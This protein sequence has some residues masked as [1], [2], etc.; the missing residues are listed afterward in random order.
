MRNLRVSWIIP[1][2]LAV[3]V[4]A[5]AALK[6]YV[7]RGADMSQ[8]QLL[9]RIEE[10]SD[11]CIL[12]VRSARE[13]GSGHIPGAINVGYKEV[14]AHLDELGPYR[15]KDII[16]YCELGVRARMAQKTLSKAGFLHV[17]HLTGDMARWRAAGLT[18]N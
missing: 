8:E 1:T 18:V 12:D 3:A 10:G 7:S 11:I 5:A 17:Y 4:I 13:Y 14:S 2:I 15:D 6:L 9:K 16:V